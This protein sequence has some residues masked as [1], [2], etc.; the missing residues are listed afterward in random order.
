MTAPLVYHGTGDA[1]D[2]EWLEGSENMPELFDGDDTAIVIGSNPDETP[3]A[4]QLWQREAA[5]DVLMHGEPFPLWHEQGKR[6][7]KIRRDPMLARLLTDRNI[8]RRR[9]AMRAARAEREVTR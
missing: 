1:V 5:R 8:E 3:A 6:E 9:P 2:H 7:G 4:G